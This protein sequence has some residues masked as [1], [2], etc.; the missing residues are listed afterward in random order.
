MNYVDVRTQEKSLYK[1]ADESLENMTELIYL[2]KTVRKV[3][4]IRRYIKFAECFKFL[5]ILSSR[6]FSADVMFGSTVLRRIFKFKS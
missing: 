4:Y 2:A 3:N 5:T 6:H 1:I